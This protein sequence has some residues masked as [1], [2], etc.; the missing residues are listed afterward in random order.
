MEVL[1]LEG[2]VMNTVLE[3]TLLMLSGKGMVT[4]HLVLALIQSDLQ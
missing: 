3:T 4:L 1:E 2:T